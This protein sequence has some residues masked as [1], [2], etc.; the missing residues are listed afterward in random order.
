M[1]RASRGHHGVFPEH[2][3]RLEAAQEGPRCACSGGPCILFLIPSVGVVVVSSCLG[4][5]GQAAG[6]TGDRGEEGR[7]GEEEGGSGESSKWFFDF[8]CTETVS[9]LLYL[10]HLIFCA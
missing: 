4:E 1:S 6:R 10:I 5:A 3:E 2:R 7:E 9:R 8:E